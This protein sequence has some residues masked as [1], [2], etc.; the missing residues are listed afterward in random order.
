MGECLFSYNRVDKRESSDTRVELA[1]AGPPN[2]ARLGDGNV[3]STGVVS[4]NVRALDDGPALR[5]GRVLAC[6]RLTWGKPRVLT[7]ETTQIP[8]RRGKLLVRPIV[9]KVTVEPYESKRRLNGLG[10]IAWHEDR[11]QQQGWYVRG[12]ECWPHGSSDDPRVSPSFT[13]SVKIAAARQ[14]P[15][16]ANRLRA[17]LSTA[18]IP[19]G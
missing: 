15:P 12:A 16:A 13:C 2:A 5:P 9:L 19:F 4:T 18:H 17:V 1:S 6:F 14:W 8:T 11:T 7:Q 3:G 10:A